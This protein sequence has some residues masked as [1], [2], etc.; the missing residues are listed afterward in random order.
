MKA[1]LATIL[2]LVLGGTISSVLGKATAPPIEAHEEHSHEEKS[3]SHEKH[4]H[5][6]GGATKRQG[7][8]ARSHGPFRTETAIAGPGTVLLTADFPGEIVLDPDHIAHVITRAGGIVRR[9]TKTIGDRVEK[10][11]VLA[12]IESDELGEAKMELYAATLDLEQARIRANRALKVKEYT[13]RLLE[14]LK[15][16]RTIQE[17]PIPGTVETGKYRES[18]LSAYAEFIAAKKALERERTLFSKGISSEQEKL[19]AETLYTK[20]REALHAAMDTSRYETRVAYLKAAS[21][22]LK[23]EF[24][25]RVAE[26][27]LKA[28]GATEQII[29]KIKKMAIEK[30]ASTR[31]DNKKGD[32]L[33]L[34]TFAW[35]PLRSPI[36][37]FVVERHL[38][39]G[40][41]IKAGTRAF[42]LADTSSVWVKF[43]IFQKDLPLVEKGMPLQIDAGFGKVFWGTLEYISPLLDRRTRSVEARTSLR[44]E[45]ETLRPGRYVTV[46]IEKKLTAPVVIPLSA[47]QNIDGKEVVFVKEGDEYR[48]VP[49][50][51]GRSDG[52][53][54]I[55]RKGLKAGEC[56]VSRGAFFLKAEL[57]AK[58]TA[59]SHTGHAH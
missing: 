47:V 18:I 12:W 11:D 5:K 40:E 1:V 3:A 52:T 34:T 15:H 58:K 2:F 33:P 43:N 42:V 36:D 16:N 9:V 45:A 30:Y 31:S 23:A 59:G 32:T 28:K 56:Y 6:T 55:V 51:T 38:S 17:T 29:R 39:I 22:L 26:Q 7:A 13:Q 35:Y 41:K 46:R 48:P 53:N 25:V 27:R 20:T 44:N 19:A 49:I 50:E 8:P 57:V 14:R 24:R 21:E 4:P 10:G 37:G 54:V